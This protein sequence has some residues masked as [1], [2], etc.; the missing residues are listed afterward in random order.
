MILNFSIQSVIVFNAFN[1]ILWQLLNH[2]ILV[3]CRFT[4]MAIVHIL[5]LQIVFILFSV[6]FKM[7]FWLNK[8]V[9]WL[10]WDWRSWLIHLNL[11]ST[12]SPFGWNN[13]IFFHKT[14]NWVTTFHFLGGSLWFDTWE[15]FSGDQAMVSSPL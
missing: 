8:F 12:F 9:H 7:I 4:S 2:D 3:P 10:R 14:H 13:S 11:C 15:S 6:L 1:W 5:L